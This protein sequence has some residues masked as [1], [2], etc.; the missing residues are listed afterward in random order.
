MY[1]GTFWQTFQTC[2]KDQKSSLDTPSDCTMGH[3][4]AASQNG[5]LL[6]ALK[7]IMPVWFFFW[8][9]W[10]IFIYDLKKKKSIKNKNT[11]E[12]AS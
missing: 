4:P 11:N 8:W 6:V 7:Y 1:S 12:Y 5:V 2:Q 9:E 10:R 3:S